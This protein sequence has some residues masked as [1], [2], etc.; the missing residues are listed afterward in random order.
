VDAGNYTFN[1]TASTTADITARALTITAHGV[2]KVYDGTTSAAVTLTDDRVSGDVFTDSY[3]SASFSNKNVGTGKTVSVSGISIAGADAG[4]YTFN[5]TA[6]TTA[7]I[8]ARVLT[9]SAH[10]VNKVYDGTTF[11]IVNLSDDRVAGDVFTDSY[12]SASFADKNVGT[13]KPVSVSGISISGA[14]AGNYT[15]NTTAST[16]ADITA[17][18]LTVTA[19]GV[20]KVYDGT[21]AASV[22]LSTDK[23]V[24]DMVFAAYT[25]ASFAD[26][27]VGTAKPVSVVGISIFGMDAGNYNLVNT[28]ASTTADITARALTI[29]AHG[30]NKVYDGTSAATVTLTDDRV[31][32]DVFTDSYAS[33]SFNNKN[34]GTAKPVSV[35]GISI[36]GADADNYTFNTTASTTADITA[37][38]LT[39]T[40]H[41]VNKV[42]DGTTAATVTLS[43]N[44]VSGD[45]FTD[46]YTSASFNNKNVGTGKPVSVSGIS[47]SGADAGNY[48]FNTTAST[49]ADITARALTITA[50]GVNKV[51]DGTT[52]ATVTLS[53]DR[54]SGDVFTDYYAS[55]FFN[56]KNVGTGKP[57]SVT[58][59]SIVGTDAGNYTFNTTA[60]TTADITAR[61]LT[62]TAHGVNKV[63]D[64]TTNATVTL[65]DD[66]VAGDVFTD[67]YTSASFAD[68]N[69]GTGKTVSVTGI[70]ISGVDA[71]NY[72]FNTTASTTADITARA[73]TITAHGVNKVYDG[74]ATASVTLSDNR[75]SGDVF[76]DSYTSASFN[77]KN[78]GTGKPVSVS[79]ISI[80]GADAGNYTFNTTASTT[81]DITA[82]ALTISATGIN[83]IYDG[84]TTATV[85]LSDNRVAGDVFTD[86]YTSASFADKNVGTGKT[87]S[88]S[89]IS[90]SGAD[91]GNYTFNTTA[92]T[93]ANITKK[94][95][96]VSATGVNKVYDGTTAATV[97][98]SDNRV[99]GD[100]FTDS[101]TTATFSDKNVGTSK[102]VSVS[103][104]SISGADAGNYSFNTSAT[105]TADITK[106][107]LTV[108]ATGV[109]KVYDGTT[110]ATV[111]L[112]DN[113][114]AGDVFTDSYTSASFADKNV[115]TGKTVSVSGISISGT[116]AGNY[117]FNTTASTTAN[118]TLRNITVSATGVNK[119][120]DGTTAATVTL[121]DNRVSGDVFTDSYTSASFATKTVG[122]GKAVSVSGISISGTDASNYNLLNTTAS[123][124]ANIT[125]R[126]LTVSAT[127]V[128]K[129]Y[130]GTTAATVTLSD[131]RVSGDV[132][133]DSYTSAAFNNKNVG[134]GKAVSVSGISISGADAGNYT[135]NTTASTT[136]DITARALT[137]TA[138]GVNK[139]YDNSTTATVTL[140]D[141]RISGDTFTAS[142]TSASFADK[143]VGTGKA[144]SVSGISISGADAGNYTFNTT[145][146]TTANI[147][148]RPIT[149]KANDQTKTYGNTFTFIGTEF[150][151]TSGSLAPGDS[152]TVTLTSAGA[153]AGATVAGSPYQIV[154][155]NP[156]FTSGPAS[157]YTFTPANGLMTVTQRDAIVGY[158]GQ[159]AFF[160]SGSSS[161]TAQVTL[162]ASV[163]DSDG[164]GGNVSNATV[165]F[166]DLLSN[167]VL[168]SN[169]KVS[170][171]SGSNVLT[172]TANTIVTL[173]SGQYGANEYLIEVTLNGSYKNTQ[174]TTAP[175]SSDAYKAAHPTIAVMIPSTVNSTQATTTLNALSPAGKYFEATSATYAMGM[176]YNKG[177]SQPQGQ[178]Q[179]ILQL[180]GSATVPGGTYYIKSNSI[181]S[182]AFANPAGSGNLP[183]DVTI[184]TKASIFKVNP[185]GGTTS[186]DG[187]VTLRVDG[188]EGCLT[189]PSC[190]T[191]GDGGDKIGFTVLSSKDGTLYYSNNWLYDTSNLAWATVIQPVPSF[192]AMIIN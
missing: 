90:I 14:D 42:Y 100:V 159:T 84:T 105:A 61:A 75:V 183:K 93:T 161:T 80:S 138:T 76:T 162:S 34:V 119:V 117:S 168:A 102:L 32:G 148:A 112:S 97:T 59:I 40:A 177:G 121:S 49:T 31:A 187:N 39:I 11:A 47:I 54:V 149:I 172:G 69:V 1:T 73:L 129:V 15:F 133:T 173:S 125:A 126:A 45:V 55:A 79:G 123:T 191:S 17:R 107:A 115:G 23:V 156:V 167:T 157:N 27:N 113:R 96:T 66:R 68:K 81:A 122:T 163:Q 144:V 192:T 146:S 52:S 88:V 57:V 62:I 135:F 127:G 160:T 92:T 153:A 77:N 87:V 137:I 36:A 131:N 147:T 19:A 86:S 98:L 7:D 130:D 171:V 10:G 108:S 16:T 124:T 28:T 43:D 134:T 71:G 6:S 33:A 184:Y 182:L 176:K 174:Q 180:P 24:G 154:P 175:T 189:S 91:A 22:N 3:T 50:H 83:K 155:S 185:G 109:N 140:S 38:A 190:S 170:P 67:S 106:R 53:D 103:G 164:S 95:L 111:T 26:K 132:F 116:D 74:T 181:T 89:G 64:G 56:N 152:V 4:N 30:V 48:T 179:L 46:S 94:Y 145:A 120:Y 169:V 165:T 41:G 101:Y 114:I 166:K 21:T 35:T 82:R 139:V 85:T 58:G 78:V 20:N 65:S 70:S 44:R 99:S 63:Y 151:V 37:R 9:I 188:H 142:Y 150:T 186:V 118:I 143:N 72:T 51:Y 12:G 29:S 13:G 8:T 136:A 25:S 178:I 141:N 18:D 5:T 128:N 60:S 2:N 104:I 158:I 110:G